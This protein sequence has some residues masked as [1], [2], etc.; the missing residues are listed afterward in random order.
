MRHPRLNRRRSPE[1]EP[2]P[3]PGATGRHGDAA[4]TARLTR[5]RGIRRSSWRM[6]RR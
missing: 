4:R 1:P 6:P 2:E 5:R 3:E